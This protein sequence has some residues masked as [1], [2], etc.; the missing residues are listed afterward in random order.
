MKLLADLNIS[1]DDGGIR[2][3]RLPV[4]SSRFLCSR[5]PARAA[6][7]FSRVASVFGSRPQVAIPYRIHGRQ[8]V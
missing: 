6:A 3:R 5:E 4:E 1:I 7:A 2:I 8:A